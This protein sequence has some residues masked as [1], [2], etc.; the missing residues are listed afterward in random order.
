MTILAAKFWLLDRPAMYP[1]PF[2]P[3]P[4]RA[5]V[6]G[7]RMSFQGLTVDVGDGPIG[8]FE[9][10]LCCL[11]P[12]QRQ[13]V[14]AAKRLAGDTH[15]IIEVQYGGML[16]NE[17]GQPYMDYQCPDYSVD[18]AALEALAEEVIREGFIPMLTM[19]ED[20]D[21]S[22]HLMQLSVNILRTA[23]VGD[24]T[25]YAIFVPGYDGVFYGWPPADIVAWGNLAKANGAQYLG[26][27]HNTA[28]IPIGNGPADWEISGA[29]SCFDTILSEFDPWGQPG[30]PPSAGDTVWQIAD[31]LLG[32]AFVRPPDMPHS[33]DPHPPW[34]L[35][36]GN[37]RGPY[38]AVAFETDTYWW[39]R[40]QVSLA[41][42]QR[43]R[44]YYKA[45]GYTW[46]C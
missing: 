46:I 25:Q 26:I 19:K 40:D 30:F 5:Q 33:D 16:Y 34:Y 24:L 28:H 4:T 41:D 36:S 23:A 6:C 17:P 37:A 44:A 20:D 10:A 35:A 21:V 13:I 14:Y 22:A 32:P 18:H 3:V 39:V 29:M 45:M 12:A 8:W 42:V 43:K 9:A 2:P 1:K 27:E 15:A 7:I 31:R 11:T 38:F